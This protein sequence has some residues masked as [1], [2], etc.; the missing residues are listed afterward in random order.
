MTWEDVVAIGQRLPGVEEGT[1]Y[2][3]PA[4]KVKAK[5]LTRLRHEDDSLVFT[6]VPLDER[7]L[8]LAMEPELFHITPH[9]Q[10]YPAVLARLSHIDEATVWKFLERRWRS[11]APAKLRAAF[12]TPTNT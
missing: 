6:D 8:L 2:G 1:S 11:V 5:F 4:L 3:T 12:D 7:E 9:Y 10:D